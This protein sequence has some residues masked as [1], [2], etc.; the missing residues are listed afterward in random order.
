VR[1]QMLEKLEDFLAF[2]VL[3]RDRHD[4]PN[5][6]LRPVLG[7]AWRRMMSSHLA[8]RRP[9]S[10]MTRRGFDAVHAGHTPGAL[11]TSPR[12]FARGG[13]PSNLRVL[14]SSCQGSPRAVN[15]S[16]RYVSA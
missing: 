3:R 5:G 12:Q 9:A 14:A 15:R 11:F 10:A 7:E 16:F 4:Q 13:N 2:G 6:A 1:L 8:E